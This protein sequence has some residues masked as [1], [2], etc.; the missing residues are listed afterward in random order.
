MEVQQA[1]N[2]QSPHESA[3]FRG[4][5]HYKT[6]KQVQPPCTLPIL[7]L[8]LLQWHNLDQ[9]GH[10]SLRSPLTHTTNIHRQTTKIHAY[11]HHHCATLDDESVDTKPAAL[12]A[13]TT[14]TATLATVVPTQ[15]KAA[16]SRGQSHPN[17][18]TDDELIPTVPA[19]H[20]PYQL[21]WH[22]LLHL[23]N[24]RHRVP[25]HRGAQWG[26]TGSGASQEGGRQWRCGP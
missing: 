21:R 25:I 5:R 11:C 13:N 19:Q 23:L 10:T 6:N 8:P 26:P 22:R 9:V 17:S 14:T 15:L 20:H 16:N 1:A 4:L 2:L 3:I 18:R 7:F 24:A 12:P